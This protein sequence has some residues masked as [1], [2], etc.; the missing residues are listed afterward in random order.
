MRRSLLVVLTLALGAGLALAAAPPEIPPYR[1]T[2]GPADAARVAA[3]TRQATAAVEADRYAEAEKA[4]RAIA[5][6]RA[7]AQGEAH[8]QTVAARF[9]LE[10]LRLLSG[11]AAEQR[12]ALREAIQLDARARALLARGRYA[13]AL[14]LQEQALAVH[15]KVFGEGHPTTARGY[16][17][18]AHCLVPLGR[19]TEA[20]ALLE[21]ALTINR[22]V[23]GE[24]HPFTAGSYHNLAFCVQEQ[25]LPARAQP[26]YEKALAIHRR[27]DGEWRP[28]T[29]TSYNNLASCLQA[30]AQYALAQPLYEKA[31]AIRRKLHGE[32]H[33]DTAQSY[34]NVA[35]CLNAQGQTDQALLLYEKALRAFRKAYGERHPD[36]ALGYNNVAS[37]LKAL[38]QHDRALP[39]YEKALTIRL[40]V[41]R[42][43]HP[44]IGVS[45]GNLASCL[46]AQGQFD[47]ALPLLEKALAIHRR[48]PGED[49]PDTAVSYRNLADGLQDQG[50]HARALPL[51]EKALAICRRA[52]GEE[53]TD[54]ATSYN[55]LALC[56]RAQG[57]LAQALPLLE[58]ALATY[59][60]VLGEEHPRTAAACNNVAGC[61]NAQGQ[62]ARALP[63]FEKAL[64][65]YRTAFGEG[66]PD[67]A[68]SYNNVA[69]CLDDLGQHAR[70]L[71]LHEKALAAS[72][73]ARG[74]EH[75]HTATSYN[76]LARCLQMQGQYARALPLYEK[77]LAIF[78]Q[79]L[80]EDHPHTAQSCDHVAICLSA[81]GRLPEAVLL[82]QASLPGQEAARFHTAATGFDRARAGSSRAS[83]HLALAWSLA[84]L[85]QPGNAF[86]HAEAG[87]ARGLLDDLASSGTDAPRM[88]A[89][90]AR[91]KALDALL[92]PLLSR[93][94]LSA[95][96][97]R[98]RDEHLAQRRRVVA[99]MVRLAAAVS[100]RQVLP[101]ERIQEQ[102]PADAALVFW[103]DEGRPPLGCVL[104]RSGPP[105]WLPLPEATDRG[106]PLRLYRALIDPFSSSAQRADLVET[107]RRQR[108]APLRPHLG[109]RGKLPAV[110]RLFVV[111]A[112]AMALVPVEVLVPEYTVSYVPS[113]SVLARLAKRHRPLSDRGLLALGNPVFAVPDSKPPEP[114]ARGLLL[115]ALHPGGSAAR[116][117]LRAG[118]VLLQ[119][120]SQPLATID[121]LKKALSQGPAPVRY[122]RD[123][124]EA[125]TAPWPAGPLGFRIDPQ[126]APQAVR[127]W[128]ERNTSVLSRGT[129]HKALPGAAREV[130]AVAALVPGATVLLGSAA[131]EQEL[132]HLRKTGELKRYRLLLFAT[133]GEVDEADPDRSR[134]ILAQDRLP[135]PLEAEPGQKAYTGELTVRTIRKDWELDADLVVLSACKTALGKETRGDGLLGFAQAFL[136]R[137]ARSVVLTRWQVDDEA[138]AILMVRFYQNLL[139]KRD[140]L[141]KGMLK[142]EALAEAK[143]WLRN[144]SAKDV[145][146]EVERL[147]RGKAARPVL[148]RKEGRP[149][150]HPYFW[151]AFVL[152]GDPR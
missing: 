84:H 11:L 140:G 104:R 96:Q 68:R 106:L 63:L 69:L 99:E 42:K 48:E 3:L 5:D 83:P 34:N 93:S 23:L 22:K 43:G 146:L 18:V 60:K 17:N 44:D 32:G 14:L 31:L 55:N 116:A 66:H 86:R 97:R 75:P 132:D 12:Q 122:W 152:I 38:G 142:A 147:P 73:K 70:A 80:G 114:P 91:L 39:L 57:H 143:D 74:E 130:R 26:L 117:G 119:W 72:R 87:L 54:T 20:Q 137:G 21:K 88:V 107:M 67:T 41:L 24:D 118:D 71:P 65:I 139:G 77:A 8:W 10:S 40:K 76:N 125:K 110:R 37:C 111:P 82:W 50:R 53:H 29:A 131:S 4:A 52:H 56:L 81:L 64:A 100:A 129:G 85:G 128:R 58:K 115:T 123:D 150:A 62:H 6:L 16:S 89:L 103:L 2:L 102:L 144:L 109:A 61:L 135:G 25:G 121:D 90:S 92:L 19:Y 105:A 95:E 148:L 145:K 151:A 33:P 124:K 149:F 126:P 134:L 51:Y 136:S 9:N 94:D 15:R 27:V 79:A 112:G 133:H 7:R 47:R 45:Y 36:T 127:R 35:H 59:R 78:R 108:L 30:Q 113:G 28:S 141:K 46:R 1:R 98:L 13:E 49:H 120:G 101:L 138:T